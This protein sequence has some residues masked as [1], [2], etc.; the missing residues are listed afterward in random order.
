VKTEKPTSNRKRLSRLNIVV[1]IVGDDPGGKRKESMEASLTENIFDLARCRQAILAGLTGCFLD[2]LS[3]DVITEVH[4]FVTNE[5]GGSCDEL[6]YFVL[7]L[8]AKRAVEQLSAVF[9]VLTVITHSLTPL[10]AGRG[11]TQFSHIDP[12]RCG[13]L[14]GFSSSA[15]LNPVFNDWSEPYPPGRNPSTVRRS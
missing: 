11:F 2:F 12:I 3:N 10:A 9:A 1:D 6:A 13:L 5:Y 8:T 4:A 14:S 7:T 15:A